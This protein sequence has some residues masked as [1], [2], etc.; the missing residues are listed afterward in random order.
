MKIKEALK[1]GKEI[2]TSA[3]LA[4]HC[5]NADNRIITVSN[6]F[7]NDMQCECVYCSI[8]ACY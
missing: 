5:C 3:C 1:S 4:G 2:G 8:G 6:K 7:E